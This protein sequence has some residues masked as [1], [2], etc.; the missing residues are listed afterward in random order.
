[1]NDQAPDLKPG[2]PIPAERTGGMTGFRVGECGHRVAES[3]WVAGFRNCERCGEAEDLTDRLQAWASGQ[4]ANVHAAVTL[5]IEQDHWLHDHQ[6]T[7]HCMHV[8]EDGV[9]IEWHAARAFVETGPPAS[10]GQLGMLR[11]A[12]DIGSDRYQFSRLDGRNIQRAIREF[13]EAAA[14]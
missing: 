11:L 10:P 5:L 4:D 1:M 3:E 7:R 2:D 12:I 14:R 13:T 9:W 6:F 8:D